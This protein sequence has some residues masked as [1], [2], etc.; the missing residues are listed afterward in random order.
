LF[1][2]DYVELI[3]NLILIHILILILIHIHIHIHIH[4]LNTV[5]FIDRIKL[6]KNS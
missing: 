5:V 1:F 3:I 4:I 6:L 2:A